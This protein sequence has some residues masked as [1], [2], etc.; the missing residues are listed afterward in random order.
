MSMWVFDVR[1]ATDFLSAREEVDAKRISIVGRGRG[2]FAALLTAAYDE[3]VHSVALEE[4][5]ATWVFNEEF[6]DIGIAYF[7][8]R[9]LT[10]GDMPQWVSCLAP[11]PVLLVNPVDGRRRRI[12]SDEAG[13]LDSYSRS[14]FARLN[15]A[16]N[17]RQIE[18]GA[19]TDWIQKWIQMVN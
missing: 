4:M 18:A 1:C 5:L 12:S 10:L 7:I 13:R 3:R 19:A 9:I 6:R 15:A 8:P 2:A 16:D 14:V 17:L 11:R